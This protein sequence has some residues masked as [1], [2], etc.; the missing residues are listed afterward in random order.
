MH[1]PRLAH[2]LPRALHP[3]SDRLLRETT[4][5]AHE[6]LGFAY[7]G[8]HEKISHNADGALL[9]AFSIPHSDYDLALVCC[10]VMN[11]LI[12]IE[13]GLVDRGALGGSSFATRGVFSR[14]MQ[15]LL[16]RQDGATPLTAEFRRLRHRMQRPAWERF[17]ASM[18]DFAYGFTTELEQWR[19]VGCTGYKDYLTQR[20]SSLGVRRLS[21][22][23]E[24][25][26]A[27]LRLSEEDFHNADVPALHDTAVDGYTLLND[28]VSYRREAAMGDPVNLVHYLKEHEE[29][30]TEGEMNRLCALIDANEATF[31]R[32]R[33][34]ALGP[35]RHD[36]AMAAYLSEVGHI[37]TSNLWWSTVSDRYDPGGLG[38]D[39]TT[40]GTL[41]LYTDHS[42]FVPDLQ[43]SRRSAPA[44]G[45]GFSRMSGEGE[46]GRP[47]AAFG[48][49]GEVGAGMALG[50][51]VIVV[52]GANHVAVVAYAP[53][54]R[55]AIRAGHPGGVRL[56]E[57][58]VLVTQRTAA[59]GYR[60]RNHPIVRSG[61]LYS[62]RGCVSAPERSRT[63][64]RDSAG[65]GDLLGERRCAPCA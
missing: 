50:L 60:R 25:A 47:Q 30:D 11:Y 5:W 54:E 48:W 9:I 49:A 12:G 14:T 28:V 45:R 2:T 7:D 1:L 35:G 36:S 59:N 43:S 33:A 15:D 22:F 8:D 53:M 57:G 13:N 4:A 44:G 38:W 26:H 29:L 10:K 24:A 39:G 46:V 34:Q 63:P 20:R 64:F 37:M 62:S 17:V 16:G 6:H 52:I 31:Q 18:E 40:P 42:T 27:E 41:T 58:V 55:G 51:Q 19:E 65:F 56:D 61:G 23:A 32:L 21:G 3:G